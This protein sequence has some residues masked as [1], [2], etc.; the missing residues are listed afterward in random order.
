MPKKDQRKYWNNRRPLFKKA[1]NIQE[2]AASLRSSQ[3]LE[4]ASR[5]ASN[6]VSAAQ[7]NFRL[8]EQREAISL[9]FPVSS[10]LPLAFLCYSE[11]RS[12]RFLVFHSLPLQSRGLFQ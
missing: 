5:Y 4:Y 8:C 7:T 2:I 11:F 12:P 10:L 3:R 1:K 6:K 9:H